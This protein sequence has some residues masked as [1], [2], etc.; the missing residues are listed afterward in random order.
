MAFFIAHSPTPDLGADNSQA[1]LQHSRTH[2]SGNR[3]GALRFAQSMH[4]SAA[5]FVK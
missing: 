2:F 4:E 3:Q 1:T 5:R